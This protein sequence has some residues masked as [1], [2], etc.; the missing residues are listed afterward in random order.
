MTSK[1]HRK[2]LHGK[3]LA[4]EALAS[5]PNLSRS[6]CRIGAVL[7]NRMHGCY[8][9]CDPGMRRLASDTGYTVDTVQSAIAI[10][11]DP[12]NPDR[13]FDN[14]NAGQGKRPS[15]RVRWDRVEA[16]VDEFDVRMRTPTVRPGSNSSRP[17][18]VRGLPNS[19]STP[20]VRELPN[21]NCSES[22]QPTVQESPN[23]TNVRTNTGP[24]PAAHPA[25]GPCRAPVF[26]EEQNSFGDT[27]QLGHALAVRASAASL[28]PEEDRSLEP[29]TPVLIKAV[30]AEERRSASHKPARLDRPLITAEQHRENEAV[31]RLEAGLRNGGLE[32]YLSAIDRLDAELQSRAVAAE[33]AEPGAGVATVRLAMMTP[34]ADRD[35]HE[36]PKRT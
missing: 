32:F 28:P 34:D 7:I 30:C 18:T 16:I 29:L 26:S 24:R 15:Y 1:E 3:P 19:S 14:L 5:V 11:C 12:S 4:Y 35:G 9:R 6:Q 36:G 31:E 27:G 25:A 17:S 2:K 8:G 22:D 21:S 10:L 13:L 33:M 23:K 20:T